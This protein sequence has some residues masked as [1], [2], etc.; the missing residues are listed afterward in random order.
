MKIVI[1]TC[2][3]GFSVSKTVYDELSFEWEDEC[4]YLENAQFGFKDIENPHKYRAAPELIAAI[5][6]IGLKKSSG[7]W[8]TLTIIDIPDDVEWD[9][10]TEDGG[11]ESIHEKHRSWE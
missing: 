8:A 11:M 10:T 2:Y 4:G 1:N 6:K 9:I 7:D 5:E 3:G